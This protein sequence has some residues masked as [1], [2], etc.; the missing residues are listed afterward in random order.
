MRRGIT[1]LELVVVLAIAGVTAGV[2][3]PV[4]RRLT[5]AVAADRAAQAVVAAHR[6]ARFSAIV[7]GRRTLLT[8]RP[9]SLH[10]RILDG[11]DTLTLWTRGGP[12]GEGVALAGAT[13]TLIFAP[14][15]LPLGASNATYQ[16]TRGGAARHVVISR[17]G[18]V[19]LVRP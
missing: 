15:G 7:R 2:A 6:I 10:V 5:D 3:L 1:L 12:A 4:A 13:H 19:R 8:V 18:R 14:T 9:E 17:L 11:S 16:L